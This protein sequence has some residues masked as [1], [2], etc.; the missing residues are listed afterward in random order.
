MTSRRH[1]DTV[2]APWLNRSGRVGEF[3]VFTVRTAG[4][5]PVTLRW[6]GRICL[7][8]YYMLFGSL[9]VAGVAGAALGTV[10]WLQ[11]HS[12]LA[13]FNSGD[14]L[15]RALAVAVLWELGPITAG[16]IAA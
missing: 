9:A 8:L 6:P 4:N 3:A 5:L 12:I 2:S 14:L 11:L 1:P 7:E 16:L 10:A 13:Q 15:P